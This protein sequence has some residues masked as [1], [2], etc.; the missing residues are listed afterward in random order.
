[1]FELEI[2]GTI[3]PFKF[4]LGFMRE[5]NK[6]VERPIKEMPGKVESLGLRYKIAELMDG[7]IETLISTLLLANKTEEP[8]I[9]KETLES[10]IEDENTD[11]D[12]LFDGVLEGLKQSNATKKTVAKVMEDLE[13]AKELKEKQMAEAMREQ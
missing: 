9:S 11:I 5:T 7:D 4:G 10:Y 3:Y 8:R 2:K 6:E 1:M 12:K 13:K